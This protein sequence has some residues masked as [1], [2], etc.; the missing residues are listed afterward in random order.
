MVFVTLPVV[1]YMALL[2]DLTC[3]VCVWNYSLTSLVVSV[4]LPVVVCMALFC[5]LTC[6]VYDLI[7]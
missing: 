1:V 3:G 6:G 2:C 7:V 5:D 4:T